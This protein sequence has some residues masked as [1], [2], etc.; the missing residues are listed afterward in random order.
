MDRGATLQEY[1]R[2][3]KSWFKKSP[4]SDQLEEVVLLD[5][6]PR[7]TPVDLPTFDPTTLLGR[8]IKNSE[9]PWMNSEPNDVYDTLED[10]GFKVCSGI[11]RLKYQAQ[12]KG[13]ARA[14]VHDEKGPVGMR[15]TID[16]LRNFHM[17]EVVLA[18]LES[19]NAALYKLREHPGIRQRVAKW[20]EMDGNPSSRVLGVGLV[21]GVLVQIHRVESK[22]LVGELFAF[23][24]KPL[25][26]Y[27][28]MYPPYSALPVSSASSSQRGVPGP[29]KMLTTAGDTTKVSRS[30]TNQSNANEAPDKGPSPPASPLVSSLLNKA[31]KSAGPNI[32]DENPD[33]SKKV[34]FPSRSS[35]PES[36]SETT[37]TSVFSHQ[38]GSATHTSVRGSDLHTM[39][40]REPFTV[41]KDGSQ[42]P[43][44][45]SYFSREEAPETRNLGLSPKL[46]MQPRGYTCKWELPAFMSDQFDPGQSISS[47]VTLT[48]TEIAALAT[49]C[50]DYV[51]RFWPY[52]GSALLGAIDELLLKRR[53][54]EYEGL[55]DM[56]IYVYFDIDGA[57][58][59]SVYADSPEHHSEV[60]DTLLWLAATF[61]SSPY[62]AVAKSRS[63]FQV[64]QY[65]SQL[66]LDELEPVETSGICWYPLF[67][68]T[69]MAVQFPV[70]PRIDGV[71][72]AISP[73]LMASMAGIIMPVEYHGGFILKG[74]STT[75]VPIRECDGGAAIQWHLVPT[76]S[77]DG[78]FDLR[79]SDSGG[80]D[81]G[82]LKVKD[83][84]TLFVKNA[85]LGWCK[86][87]KI[88]L[89]TDESNYATVNWSG[90]APEQSRLTFSGFA[91][92]FSSSGMGAFGPSA[93]MN[94]A[95]AKNQ[96][97]R[98]MDID[99]Q[100]ADRLKLSISKPAL[101]Y[102]T[103]TQRGW[104]IPITSLLL[105]MM[106]LRHR[107]LNKHSVSV[108]TESMPYSE[109]VGEGGKEAYKVLSTYLRP[110]SKTP[111]GPSTMWRDALAI[112]CTALD[113]ALKDARDMKDKLSRN[114]DSEI[115]GFELLNIVRADSPFR[116][117]E[118]K[119]QKQ[120]GGWAL[121][122]QQIGYVLFC[123]GLGDAL[124][125]GLSANHLCQHWMTVPSN[126]DYLSA[127]V[128][129][130]REVLEQQGKH[131]GVQ[132]LQDQ[133][134]QQI[135]YEECTHQKGQRCFHL[136]SYH[137]L[138]Q[139]FKE[140]YITAPAVTLENDSSSGSRG[141][142]IFGK[143]TKLSKRT[144]PITAETN[145]NATTA[146]PQVNFFRR[147]IYRSS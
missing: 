118:R 128:P 147:V 81:I 143:F 76:Q 88:L 3:P 56:G 114:E 141:A 6:S 121:I 61:R 91:L 54:V 116:F 99:Q 79:T 13:L 94:F 138:L 69:S 95:V 38:I 5:F 16:L 87:A 130:V 58:G 11:L 126:C 12:G 8:I 39:D 117:S 45:S 122:A 41:A 70:P 43:S 101:I 73:A 21:T 52:G 104:L 123:S 35:P 109:T 112:L 144:V 89:G 66:T 127:Y 134:Y 71:G 29:L 46:H 32:Y 67:T 47:V 145:G 23:R 125:P 64:V 65:R 140:P 83:P 63:S 74:L 136:K 113:M 49:T 86:E 146:K 135:L 97:A 27:L 92:G 26:L 44:L 119:V 100:L 85:Y 15:G 98:F 33:K 36:I 9:Q 131:Q 17:T 62:S 132:M 18:V 84:K 77:A 96:Q 22:Y 142:I 10:S 40:G 31:I 28:T 106:H 68:H 102:D 124:V 37:E 4:S 53:M 59:V 108:S 34:R 129:C 110:G 42:K 1:T 111:L 80:N 2:N 48:G 55:K 103:A 14:T 133:N 20:F 30:G 107:E 72:L 57:I 75:L 120:S 7:R 139:S 105:H 50:G 60:A 78:S 51:S 90:P 19:T 115:Y 93:T 137:G 25:P 24:T 82:F